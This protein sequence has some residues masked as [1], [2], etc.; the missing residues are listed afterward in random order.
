MSYTNYNKDVGFRNKILLSP[1]TRMDSLFTPTATQQHALGRILEA[2]DA[3][4]RMWRYCKA[5][6]VAL[7]QAFMGQSEVPSGNG[8]EVAQAGYDFADGDIRFDMLLTTGHGYANQELIDGLLYVN[9]SPT[10]GAVVGSCHIIKD[11]WI[12]TADTVMTIEIADQGGL[13]LTAA[14]TSDDN[15]LSVIKSPYMDTV[16]KPANGLALSI[17]VPNVAVP[18]NYY[19]WAQFKGWCPVIVDDGETLVI[20]EPAG[21]PGTAGDAGAIGVVAN[22][23]TDEVWGTVVTIGATDEPAI[24]KLDLPF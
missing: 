16:I 8:L 6:G 1:G 22:D 4:G 7:V 11:N 19:Y 18:I 3:T 5:G 14:L 24:I 21:Q 13:R 9:K 2:D 20:G 10:D 17:G 12:K 15:E 23:G